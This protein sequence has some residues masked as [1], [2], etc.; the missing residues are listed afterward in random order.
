MTVT[1]RVSIASRI[2]SVG[3]GMHPPLEELMLLSGKAT[4]PRPNARRQPSLESVEPSPHPCAPRGEHEHAD[5]DE[6]KPG[7][8]REH[9]ERESDQD[10]RNAADQEKH[11]Y[12]SSPAL[13]RLAEENSGKQSGAVALL[14]WDAFSGHEPRQRVGG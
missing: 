14:G 2:L 3:I 8:D 1:V 9:D 4:K 7:N 5:D 12:D 11:P 6:W 10:Q 13:D